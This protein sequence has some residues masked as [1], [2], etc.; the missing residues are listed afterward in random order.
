M[1]FNQINDYNNLKNK[2]PSK[3]YFENNA[4]FNIM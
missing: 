2:K 4:F 1:Q 3:L